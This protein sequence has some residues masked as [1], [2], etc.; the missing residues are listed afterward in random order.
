[1]SEK[2][3][4]STI[5]VETGNRNRYLYDRRLKKNHISHPILHF[6]ARLKEHGENPGLWVS[7][8]EGDSI[9]IEDGGSFSREEISYY[10][11][12]FQ[13]LMA[14]GF[15]TAL[16]QEKMVSGQV[17]AEAIQRTI[18]NLRQITFEVTDACNL[19]CGYCA[20]G[21]FYT[22]Y[23]PRQNKFM[24]VTA[25]KGLIN[26]FRDYLDSPLN[27]SFE[28]KTFIGFYGGEPLYKKK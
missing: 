5:A 21:N 1:M 25:A 24:D 13:M 7:Q 10:Y 11:K 17:T 22:D 8:Q 27:L 4:F 15:F 19:Q 3:T 23:Q 14:N 9:S 18:A 12:K 6:F 2:K 28:R 20:Y 16:P 26:Y